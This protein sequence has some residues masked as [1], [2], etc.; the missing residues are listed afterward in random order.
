MGDSASTSLLSTRSAVSSTPSQLTPNTRSE[1]EAALTANSTAQTDS[2]APTTPLSDAAAARFEAHL[3]GNLGVSRYMAAP[4]D[5]AGAGTL[6]GAG[7]G[8]LDGAGVGTLDSAG[9][10]KAVDEAKLVYRRLP[11]PTR[12]ST[13]NYA[14][15]LRASSGI[16]PVETAAPAAVVE[17]RSTISTVTISPTQGVVPLNP[18]NVGVGAGQAEALRRARPMGLSLGNLARKQSWNEQDFKH[19]NSERLMVKAPE[20]P[21]YSS[22]QEGGST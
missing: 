10:G 1:A 11:N 16:S 6:D 18:T 13:S 7:A 20:D 4:L 3:A 14:E 8:T 15:A 17:P 19:V 2:A 9:A 21:G 5:G 12:T 22:A